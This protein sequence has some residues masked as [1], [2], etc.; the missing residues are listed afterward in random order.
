[1]MA[2]AIALPDPHT[3]GDDLAEQTTAL[4]ARMGGDAIVTVA[5]H[6][7]AVIDRR[8]I[9]DAIKRVEAYF[10]PIKKMAHTL[11][12]ELCDRENAIVNP[13]RAV[14]GER[15]RAISAYKVIED[16]RRKDAERVEADR[17]KAEQDRYALAEAAALERDGDRASA[18]MVIADAVAA[19]A[20]VVVLPDLVRTVPGAKFARRW[21]YRITN[22][23]LIP[24]EYLTLDEKK[25]GAYARAMKASA[26]VPG[27]QFYFTDD[28]VR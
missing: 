9:G 22:E 24:R 21:H 6:A 19:P 11:W 15:A 3:V 27:V 10:A 17:R 20:P 25:L 18:A 8:E 16:E 1:M 23:A 14:D 7:Q 13:L 4:A 5:D 2:P 28:P 26:C 12:R